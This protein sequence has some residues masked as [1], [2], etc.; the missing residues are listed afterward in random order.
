MVVRRSAQRITRVCQQRICAA[1]RGARVHVKARPSPQDQHLQKS[2]QPASIGKTARSSMLVVGLQGASPSTG[3]VQH[4]KI[5]RVASGLHH[6]S[7]GQGWVA[8]VLRWM[9]HFSHSKQ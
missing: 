6:K 4:L 3:I 9:L 7:T 2:L 1:A 5:S 8:S